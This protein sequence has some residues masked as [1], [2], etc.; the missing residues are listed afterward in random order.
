MNEFRPITTQMA[1]IQNLILNP[2]KL[3]GVCGRLK[4]CLAYEYDQYAAQPALSR[5]PAAV[6]AD[7]P[8]ESLTLMSDD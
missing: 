2:G 8:V 4:C 5:C 3:S 1:K 7:E 6:T